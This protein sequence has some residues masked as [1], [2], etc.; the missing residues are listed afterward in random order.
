MKRSDVVK[1]MVD[2]WRSGKVELNYH[3]DEQ[4]MDFI[5]AHM[6]KLD[7]VSP[8]HQERRGTGYADEYG[9]EEIH[10]EWVQGWEAE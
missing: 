7:I 6:E 9:F 4:A 10:D 8:H 1:L 5:L 3:S 2:L